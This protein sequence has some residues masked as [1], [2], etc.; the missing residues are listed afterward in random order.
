M[1]QFASFIVTVDGRVLA[2]DL[3]SHEGIAVG[4]GIAPG[5]YREAE[6]TR[7]DDGASLVIRLEPGEGRDE[8]IEWRERVF[9]R[10]PTRKALLDGITE[11]RAAGAQYWLRAGNRHRIDGPAV[12]WA[13]GSQ[14][15]WLEGKRHRVD[16]P[17]VVRAN[18]TQEW[19]VDG[20][21]VWYHHGKRH[22]TDG[23]AVEGADGTREWWLDGNYVRSAHVGV[24]EGEPC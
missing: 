12:M 18:G 22:R 3:M 5:D 8:E 4:Y 23:P 17:A 7:D 16:G 11:G 15:W 2:G 19:W 20:T 1:C 6:W 21:Q 13:D 14:E 10:Y 24:E 9:R